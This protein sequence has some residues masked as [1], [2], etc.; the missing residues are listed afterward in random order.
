MSFEVEP[1]MVVDATEIL[2]YQL[3]VPELKLYTSLIM[4]KLI[5]KYVGTIRF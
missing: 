4:L 1:L 5:L 3:S 2:E